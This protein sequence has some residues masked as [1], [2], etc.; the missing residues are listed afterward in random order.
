MKNMLL[1]EKRKQFFD[2]LKLFVDSYM[3]E[4]Q[5]DNKHDSFVGISLVE[6]AAAWIKQWPMEARIEYLRRFFKVLGV[7]IEITKTHFH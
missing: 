5:S 7:K 3:S 2:S 1:E 4:G 6:I